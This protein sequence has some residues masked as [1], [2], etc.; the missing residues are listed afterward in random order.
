MFAGK[1]AQHAFLD[2]AIDDSFRKTKIPT[3]VNKFGAICLEEDD[4]K[5]FICSELGRDDIE[6]R[7]YEV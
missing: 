7:S 6:I 5:N 1:N 3:F 4:L 2:L